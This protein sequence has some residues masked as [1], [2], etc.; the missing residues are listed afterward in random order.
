MGLLKNKIDEYLLERKRKQFLQKLQQISVSPNKILHAENYVSFSHIGLNGDIVY[1]IPAMLAIAKGKKI[2]LYLDVTQKTMYKSN[3]Q[4]Y[5]KDKILTK[6]SVEFITPLI[7]SNPQFEICKILEKE[8]I[9]YDLNEFRKYPF[10][11]RMG[12]ICRWY[13]LTFGVSYDLSKPWLKVNSNLSF[14]NDIVIA[15]SFRYRTLG[16]NY[17]FLKN[18]NNI[19]FIGLSEEFEDIK[20]QIP[21]IE[22]LKVTNALEMAEII[23]GCKY[24][25][26]N[27]SFP[28]SIAESLK[29]RRVLE[30]SN[31]SPNVIVDGEFG[32]DFC[33][34]QQFEKIIKDLEN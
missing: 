11:Y 12:H 13:F 3:M 5:N 18:Y 29:V 27:Q 9:D 1:S 20:Q 25:I 6:S 32:Y 26:G 14:K 23:A 10:D 28:F 31:E 8:I 2:R 19:K 22:L 24:F 30:L 4:H 33:F 15:R 16:I 17:S 21:K 7:L 34:Q